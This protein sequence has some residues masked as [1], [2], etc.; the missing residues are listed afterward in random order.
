MTVQ[1]TSGPVAAWYPDPL[2]R[3]E[4]RYWEGKKW[5]EHVADAGRASVDDAL[6]GAAFAANAHA[7]GMPAEVEHQHTDAA[8]PE[9]KYPEIMGVRRLIDSPIVIVK[10]CPWETVPER[11]RTVWEAAMLEG[12]VPRVCSWAGALLTDRALLLAE[13]FPAHW[14]A[15]SSSNGEYPS[16]GR[17]AE[18][19]DLTDISEVDENGFTYRGQH[20]KVNWSKGDQTAVEDGFLWFWLRQ[21]PE[22]APR[23]V[24]QDEERRNP[25]MR[26]ANLVLGHLDYA[27]A[28]PTPFSAPGHRTDQIQMHYS[29]APTQVPLREGLGKKDFYYELVRCPFCESVIRIRIQDGT[30]SIC[31]RGQ[32]GVIASGYSTSLAAHR[33][34]IA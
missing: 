19:Y 30:Y 11:A 22:L 1:D 27:S 14:H 20:R 16:I 13:R 2:H 24:V 34:Q 8:A 23:L 10:A 18:R 4:F 9:P 29:N 5:T 15:T 28:T 12:E 33:L 3:H 32:A 7:Q 6:A 25:A 17:K 31:N 21:N 26:R